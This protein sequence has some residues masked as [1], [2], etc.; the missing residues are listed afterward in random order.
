MSTD[1]EKLLTR[2]R[3]ELL[4]RRLHVLKSLKEY[5]KLSLCANETFVVSTPHALAWLERSARGDSRIVTMQTLDDT[6]REL[7]ALIRTEA[8]RCQ[9]GAPIEAELQ[10]WA[11]VTE[12]LTP[13]LQALRLTY[14]RDPACCMKIDYIRGVLT[15]LVAYVRSLKSQ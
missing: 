13:G 2:P 6:V 14:Q 3:V 9:R 5:E 7:D 11:D 10:S 8:D 12:Q 4:L 1:G 15:T